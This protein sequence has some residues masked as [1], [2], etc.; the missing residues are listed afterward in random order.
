MFNL[1]AILCRVIKFILKI[2]VLMKKSKFNLSHNASLTADMGK[3]VPFMVLDCIPN[4]SFQMKLQSFVRAQ[5]MLAP[6]MHQVNLYTQYWFV[7]Y[8]ILWD[9]W[10][11]FITGG[12]SGSDA[13]TFPTIKVKP[14]VSS[15]SDYFGLPVK[16]NGTSDSPNYQEFEVSALPYRAYAEI[17]NTRYRDEDLQNELP[18]SYSDGLDETTN[19]Q[20]A[21]PSWAK[22]YF[23]TAR[24]FT[25]RGSQISV[26]VQSM[27]SSQPAK[28]SA[29]VYIDSISASKVHFRMS[30]GV[31]VTISNFRVSLS[32]SFI[33]DGFFI[34][35]NQF[36]FSASGS[37]SISYSASSTKGVAS[38]SSKFNG[39]SIMFDWASDGI[40]PSSTFSV[41]FNVVLFIGP[42]TLSESALS[43]NVVLTETPQDIV[44]NYGSAVVSSV[45]IRDLRLSSALQRYQERS[46]EYGN[47]YEEFIQREFG[48][49]PRDARIQ[50][51]EYLGG[52]KSILQIS[53][54]LQ[55]A[56]GTN[57][58][59][60]TMRGHAVSAFSPRGIRFRCPEHGIIIGL[61]SIRP[62]SVYTQG[63]NRFW[64][65]FS[66]LDYFVPELA[67]VG[68]Q[69]VF[70]SEIYA[71][72]NNYSKIFGY[73]PRYAEYRSQPNRIAGEFRTSMLD[74]WNLARQFD[75]EPSLNSDFITMN[76]S[77]RV[78]AEQTQNS[79]LIMLRNN[80]KAYRV[81]P[82][83]AKNIL[84]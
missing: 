3:L 43:T 47:R 31:Y 34:N 67:N 44:F 11:D 6:L 49:R 25:Q 28:V 68:M 10:T 64:R 13:P 63:L 27:N 32:D 57:T 51:P 18:I 8:R 80:I 75:A 38:I 62:H 21:Q 66:K 69:E 17:W 4:D 61:L 76:P 40:T 78:F 82:K 35:D 54:V 65:K 58:G 30:N 50:R 60:G 59:V 36:S 77:K 46:L 42:K 22:D 24:P 20:L 15:L 19:T 83:H 33:S 81:V 84:K 52:G 7:P 2:G 26:P 56:E 23:T 9:N 53:E 41:S 39:L 12:I 48:I 74:F 71:D 16:N 1:S 5:P 29:S 55:T 14:E 79:F 73:A 72:G 37:F 45:N 70:S